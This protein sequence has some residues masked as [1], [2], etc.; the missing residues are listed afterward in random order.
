MPSPSGVTH[1]VELHGFWNDEEHRD[2][3]VVASIDDGGLRALLHD[4]FA[5]TLAG[6]LTEHSAPGPPADATAK[7]LRGCRFELRGVLSV[8]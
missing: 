5:I 7:G 4:A 3:R 6:L 2:L 1:H 8:G